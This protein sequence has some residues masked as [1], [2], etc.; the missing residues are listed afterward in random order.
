M[1]NANSE[2]KKYAG[3]QLIDVKNLLHKNFKENKNIEKYKDV[4]IKVSGIMTGGSPPANIFLANKVYDCKNYTEPFFTNHVTD[5]SKIKKILPWGSVRSGGGAVD[6]LKM[7]T[8]MVIKKKGSE[9]SVHTPTDSYLIGYTAYKLFEHRDIIQHMLY[10]QASCEVAYR[11]DHLSS[12]EESLKKKISK[13][14]VQEL[15]H[16]TKIIPIK[17]PIYVKGGTLVAK[18]KGT[19]NSGWWD[20]G[21]YNKNNDNKLPKRLSAH[22]GKNEERTFRFADCP[23]D[24]F[25]KDL[26]KAYYKKIKKNRCGPKEIK[27]NK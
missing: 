15:Q 2:Q 21:L 17:K 27:K 18:T 1:E 19:P 7:H 14:V 4:L 12:I 9:V 20:F 23:Y 24:Y 8:Y 11:F 25:I 3:N 13:F 6:S 16:E 5:L 22:K 26:K 10:F